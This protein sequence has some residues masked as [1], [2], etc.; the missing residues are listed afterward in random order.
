MVAVDVK[1]KKDSN[2]TAQWYTKSS[3]TLYDNLLL[4][5]RTIPD[6][7]IVD[8]RFFDYFLE[9]D[10]NFAPAISVFEDLNY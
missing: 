1:K 6:K 9:Q 4:E 3:D 10:F 5:K 2:G 7:R 8:L